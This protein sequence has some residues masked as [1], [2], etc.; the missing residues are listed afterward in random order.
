MMAIGFNRV[1]TR[2]CANAAAAKPQRLPI[3]QTF[4]DLA[5]MGTQPHET[6]PALPAPA[7][8]RQHIAAWLT[9]VKD[10]GEYTSRR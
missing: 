8:R 6:I 10:S 9:G 4:Q 5:K 1:A 7:G 2:R 3:D